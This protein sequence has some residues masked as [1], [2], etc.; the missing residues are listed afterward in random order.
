[1][2]ATTREV[3]HVHT[4]HRQREGGGFVVRRPFP[5]RG[6]ESLD[7][8]LMVDEL[9]PVTYGPGEAIGAPDHPHRGFE[10]V[11]YV[12]QGGTV[13]E[14]SVGNCS[15]IGP[16]GAQWMTAGD[17]L[18]HSEMPETSLLEHGGTMHGFQIWVNLPATH[19]RMR[20]RYQDIAPDALPTASTDGGKV[21]V[22][23]LAGQALGVEAIVRTVTPIALQHWT[24]QP[25]GE[26]TTPVS[27]SM[28]AGVYVFSG[29]L[30]VGDERRAIA[31]G[32]IAVMG[33]GDTLRLSVEDAAENP[34][35]AL[36]LA[37]EPIGEPVAWYGPFVMNTSQELEEAIRDYQAGRMGRI[38]R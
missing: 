24:L 20:P 16:G 12:L 21:Q 32:Q 14:D 10:T 18:V 17:G 5:S 1:M 8:F 6:L 35:E 23:V 15:V 22:R 2:S 9:G 25:G 11:T 27:P 37:G 31:A 28:N 19:K 29:S 38:A 4:A 3:T 33:P 34:A 26:V 7:P 30:R 13:H 36:L